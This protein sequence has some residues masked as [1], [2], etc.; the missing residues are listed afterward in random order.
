[1]R[2]RS[3]SLQ[4]AFR[5]PR[6]RRYLRQGYQEQLILVGQP[7]PT[8]WALQDTRSTDLPRPDLPPAL[9]I[10]WRPSVRLPVTETQPRL[11]GHNTSTRSLPLTHPLINRPPAMRPTG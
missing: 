7:P 1:M 9:E 2:E 10:S 5:Q 6:L 3:N 4:T 8:M 11:R